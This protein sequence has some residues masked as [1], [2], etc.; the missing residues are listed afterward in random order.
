MGNW[1]KM[2]LRWGIVGGTCRKNMVK[3]VRHAWEIGD[4]SL[5][6]D[7]IYEGNLWWK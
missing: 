3:Y 2:R 6:C 4:I 5:T 7:D 1:T